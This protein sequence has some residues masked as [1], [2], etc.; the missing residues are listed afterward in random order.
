MWRSGQAHWQESGAYL[1]DFGA[2]LPPQRPQNEAP[3]L[4]RTSLFDGLKPDGPHGFMVVVL[5]GEHLTVRVISA[6]TRTQTHSKYH[7]A[8]KAKYHTHTRTYIHTYTLYARRKT[9]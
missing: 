7:T 3:S 4:G 6:H 5:S 1:Q 9:T 8:T 2:S